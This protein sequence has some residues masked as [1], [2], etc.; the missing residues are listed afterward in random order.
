M[1]KVKAAVFASGTGSNF[2][3]MLQKKF[4]EA[5]IVLLVCDRPDAKVIEIADK[6]HIPV[7]ARPPMDFPSKAAYEKKVLKQLQ[8]HRVEWIFLAGYMRLIGDTLLSVFPNRIINI[9]PSLLPAFPG[10]EAIEQAVRAGVKV[11]GVTIHFVDSG[12]DT[13]QIIAQQAVKMKKGESLSQLTKRIQSV[14]H[15]L[16]PETINKLLSRSNGL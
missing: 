13:G 7:Y 1:S 6:Y 11:T 14:E 12:M 5:E 15:R 3:A 8:V 16:Y 2:Q 9:H 4:L 10:K